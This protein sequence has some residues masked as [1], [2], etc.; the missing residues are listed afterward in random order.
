MKGILTL[1][2]AVAGLCAAGAILLLWQTDGDV[3]TYTIAVLM[4]LIV[5][6]YCIAR[7][8]TEISDTWTKR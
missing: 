6:P 5:A 2:W 3:G 1:I 8:I 4:V 7:A